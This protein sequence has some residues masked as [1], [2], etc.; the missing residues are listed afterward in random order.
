M[1]P[2]PVSATTP[3]AEEL[4]GLCAL[5]ETTIGWVAPALRFEKIPGT[6]LHRLLSIAKNVKELTPHSEKITGN[7]VRALLA[8]M[9]LPSFMNEEDAKF[10]LE[11]IAVKMVTRAA[12]REAEA[13]AVAAAE[14]AR[15][16]AIGAARAAKR[17]AIAS[18]MAPTTRRVDNALNVHIE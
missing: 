6:P 15:K 3:V 7:A 8:P 5:E 13:E 18:R 2:T 14:E 12:K 1:A 17:A 11:Q 10:C 16:M 9:P 4:C